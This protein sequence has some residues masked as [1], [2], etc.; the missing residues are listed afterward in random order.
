MRL[1]SEKVK[2]ETARYRTCNVEGDSCAKDTL[3]D[4]IIIGGDT[5]EVA[6][7]V[8]SLIPR[9]IGLTSHTHN[10]EIDGCTEISQE[11][12]LDTASE[13]PFIPDFYSDN[14]PRLLS[15]A[16]VAGEDSLAT[17]TP[18]LMA[19]GPRVHQVARPHLAS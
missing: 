10:F 11:P 1:S 15:S 3:P 13:L 5:E 6:G 8:V 18:D 2:K 16:V 9:G 4:S 12:V 17:Q 14:L 7:S 19:S